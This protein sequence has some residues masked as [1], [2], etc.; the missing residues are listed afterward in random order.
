MSSR[1]QIFVVIEQEMQTDCLAA[2]RMPFQHAT[3]E[4]AKAEAERLA[5][6]NP[7]HKFL[8][9]ASIGHA[10]VEPPPSIWVQHDDISF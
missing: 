7:G 1:F 8:A 10:R 3:I 4:A 6:A 2:S 5:K 9:F